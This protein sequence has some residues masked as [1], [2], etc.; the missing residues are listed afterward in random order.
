MEDDSGANGWIY[1]VVD[2][3]AALLVPIDLGGRR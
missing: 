2:A 3:D 1:M